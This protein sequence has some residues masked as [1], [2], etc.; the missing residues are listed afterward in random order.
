MNRRTRQVFTSIVAVVALVGMLAALVI[1][2]LGAVASPEAPPAACGEVTSADVPALPA[3]TPIVG[4]TRSGGSDSQAHASTLEVTF[5]QA[6]PLEE[7]RARLESARPGHGR[8]DGVAYR[9][10]CAG[11]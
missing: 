3:D 11:R 7:A 4:V 1:G 2:A 6:V 9:L 8:D 5:E 10:A